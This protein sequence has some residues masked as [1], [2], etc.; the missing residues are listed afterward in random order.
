MNSPA[1]SPKNS[2]IPKTKSVLKMSTLFY[3]VFINKS[4]PAL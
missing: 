4:P 1:L 3:Y 2:K